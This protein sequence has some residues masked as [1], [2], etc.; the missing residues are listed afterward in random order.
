MNFKNTDSYLGLLNSLED[1]VVY[2]YVTNTKIKF[3][4]IM[5]IMEGYIRDTE[6]KTIFT[7][8]HEAYVALVSNPFFDPES[9]H[10]ITS[11]SFIQNLDRI[12]QKL[13]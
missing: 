8:M 11:P 4:V 5:E 7:R 3:I 1:S 10:M 9:S 2:G 6:M 13:N 12:C